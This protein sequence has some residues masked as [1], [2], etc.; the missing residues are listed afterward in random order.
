MRCGMGVPCEGDAITLRVGER[1]DDSAGETCK[2]LPLSV[3]RA[4]GN[5][6]AAARM[7]IEPDE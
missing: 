5:F 4:G 3:I 2:L 1:G 6:P 7:L